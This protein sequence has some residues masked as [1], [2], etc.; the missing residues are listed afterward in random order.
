MLPFLARLRFNAKRPLYSGR[1][2]FDCN[3]EHMKMGNYS[4]CM[5][6]RSAASFSAF[7]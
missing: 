1:V 3:S 6:P 2:F 5:L 7:Q 4:F